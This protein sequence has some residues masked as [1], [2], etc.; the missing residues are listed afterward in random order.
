M[1]VLGGVFERDALYVCEF[2]KGHVCESEGVCERKGV[3]ERQ[4]YPV[5]VQ[6]KRECACACVSIGE[7]GGSKEIY[8]VLRYL[9]MIGKAPSKN[10]VGI[11]V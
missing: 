8:F 2:T 4:R 9:R 3:W 6:Q 5:V 1:G 10:G 7:G 11:S